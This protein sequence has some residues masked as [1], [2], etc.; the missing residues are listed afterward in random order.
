MNDEPNLD[1]ETVTPEP[2]APAQPSQPTE[3]EKE[4]EEKFSASSREANLLLERN[5]ALEAQLA[6]R[7]ST[8][9]P[10][11]SELQAAFPEWDTLS[12]FEKKMARRTIAAERIAGGAVSS[13]EEIKAERSWNTS[14][15][16]ELAKNTALQGKELAFRQYAARPQYR[17]VPMDVLTA[18]FLQS[19]GTTAPAPTPAPARPTL[20]QGNGGPKT[21]DKPKKL[22]ADGL[23]ALRKTDE[24]AYVAYIIA[25]P[26]ALDDDL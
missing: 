8:K 11:D 20:L 26:D 19:Q 17:N 2:A 12:D 4:L 15:E 6:D 25:N 16:L 5:K 23:R 18:A 21:P 7:N 14:I 9:E 13:L 22:D 1:N 3:R 24:K 10:T